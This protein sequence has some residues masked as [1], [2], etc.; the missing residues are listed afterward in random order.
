M[1]WMTK[2][3]GGFPLVLAEAHGARVTDVDGHEYVDFCLGDTGAMAGHAPAHGGRGG[4]PERAASGI[5]TMLPTEDAAWVGEELARR[6][7][8][9]RWQFA[10]IGDR[11]Q[12][13]GPA[14]GPRTI[15]AARR[16][17]SSTSATTAR[18]TRRSSIAARTGDRARRPGNVG[19]PVDPA[20]DHQGRRVQRRRRPREALADGDVAC[21]LDRAGA[22]QHRHRP[23]GARLPRRA[24]R[25]HARDRHAARDRR[26]PHDQRRPRR[27]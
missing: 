7:G 11:R 14:H 25:A 10:L 18:S 9:P 26:D 15:T 1:S 5:T 12:P 16:S 20:D 21:V 27:R 24:A 22:H 6:F 17:S 4:A 3:A 13:L 2:W 19:P 23:A 8:V